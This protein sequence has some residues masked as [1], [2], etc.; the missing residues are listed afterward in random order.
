MQHTSCSATSSFI[1]LGT[2][3]SLSINVVLLLFRRKKPHLIYITI[4]IYTALASK[5]PSFPLLAS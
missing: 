1:L 4:V 2:Y 3:Y 5:Y